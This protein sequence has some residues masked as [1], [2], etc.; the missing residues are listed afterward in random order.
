MTQC[1]CKFCKQCIV[2][3]VALNSNC[4]GT[5]DECNEMDLSLV[6][7]FTTD[8]VTNNRILKLV[9][10]CPLNCS[11]EDQVKNMANHV[12]ECQ[13]DNVECPFNCL[14]CNESRL[15][16]EE[17]MNH[18]QSCDYD[19]STML[20][21]T[22]IHLTNE[23]KSL[24]ADLDLEKRRTIKLEQKIDTIVE[25]YVSI[26][27]HIH[28]KIERVEM[29]FTASM[30]RQTTRIDS[31]KVSI[32]HN[33]ASVKDNRRAMEQQM[34]D[35]SSVSQAQLNAMSDQICRVDN[36][37][38]IILR[39]S[40]ELEWSVGNFSRTRRAARLLTSKTFS[41][42]PQRGLQLQLEMW[43][44]GW[45]SF[46]GHG[47]SLFV[48]KLKGWHDRRQ[49]KPDVSCDI[50]VGLVN[51]ADQ[52]RPLHNAQTRSVVFHR[53]LCNPC[54]PFDF[55]CCDVFAV[56]LIDDCVVVRCSVKLTP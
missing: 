19:H 16:R 37:Y 22:I 27:Q 3:Y 44:D 2:D 15:N 10:K 30:E 34:I 49:T 21:E 48:D 6:D 12:K 8:I 45:G 26:H 11:H 39:N 7:S 43:P 4:P 18:V 41:T 23:N 55:A 29:D 32:D 42:A 1:E 56:P 40:G 20:M 24:K 53:F 47:I 25:E 54:N 50:T 51:M 28:N 35:L 46:R 38:R 5:S 33:K 14:G 31:L 17:F 36:Q 13:A 9:V 52:R